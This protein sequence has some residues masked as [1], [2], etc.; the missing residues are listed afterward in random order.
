M[1]PRLLFVGTVPDHRS[2]TGARGRA[3]CHVKVIPAAYEYCLQ[4]N[5]RGRIMRRRVCPV[6][7][8][9]D[10]HRVPADIDAPSR[11]EPAEVSLALRERGWSPCRV[12][13][14]AT[15]GAWVAAVIYRPHVA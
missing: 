6:L 10:A 12:W 15:E 2:R 8:E 7:I 11:A 13:F 5:G 1:A 9:M 3:A 4:P 14:D